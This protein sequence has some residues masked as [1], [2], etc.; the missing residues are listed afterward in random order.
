VDGRITF[1]GCY[2][3]ADDLLFF[4]GMPVPDDV[5]EAIARLIAKERLTGQYAFDFFREESTGRFFVIE[6][7]PRASS[8]L[9]GVSGTP[10]WGASF[11]G[12]D[13]RAKSEFQNVGFWFHQNC[14]P[15]AYNTNNR[16]EGYWSWSDP[17]PVL[18]AE[19]A[20]PL[21]M[22][23][24]KGA[25][26][27]GELSRAPKGLPIESGT[28]LTA[29]FPSLCEALGLN[30]HHL[31][32]N[33]GKIIVPGPTLGRDYAVFEAIAAGNRE[34]A[35]TASKQKLCCASADSLAT[36]IMDSASDS[37]ESPSSEDETEMVSRQRC[38]PTI[39]PM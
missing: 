23:R 24:I 29:S 11:F 18:I 30:Y 7:N 2:R 22:L 17:L 39:G 6:C 10:G 15:F 36:T 8:V 26:K 19:I 35:L 32:V 38:V 34:A 33:I 9:E 20:W 5:E 12:E 16:I 21:E 28:P 1:Q 14:G 25:L 13:V 27:G 4:D 31:D 3:S 37:Q